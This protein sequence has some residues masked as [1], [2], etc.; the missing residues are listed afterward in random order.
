MRR[1]V[2][3][4]IAIWL[5]ASGTFSGLYYLLFAAEWKGWMLLGAG[6]VFIVGATLFY[7]NFMGATGNEKG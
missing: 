2:T 6:F 7:S 1:A 4:I 3:F 5:T